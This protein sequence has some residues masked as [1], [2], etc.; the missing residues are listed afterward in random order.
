LARSFFF[1]E[2]FGEQIILQVLKILAGEVLPPMVHIQHA[3]FG[4]EN[5]TQ[6][7]ATGSTSSKD[8]P[9]CFPF[10]ATDKKARWQI[11]LLR[12]FVL[13]L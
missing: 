8:R 11:N 4:A 6:Y 5:L 7:C 13:R 3:F 1:L 10:C 9:P 12:G 2:K